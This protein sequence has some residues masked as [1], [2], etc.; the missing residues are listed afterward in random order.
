MLPQWEITG[1]SEGLRSIQGSRRLSQQCIADGHLG[2]SGKQASVPM[3]QKSV[4]MA[5]SIQGSRRAGQQRGA[6]GHLGLISRDVRHRDRPPVPGLA[7][8]RPRD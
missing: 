4:S 1:T 8:A 5:G 3:K 6:D 2:V 7:H